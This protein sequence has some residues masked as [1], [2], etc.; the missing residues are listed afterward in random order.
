MQ[1]NKETEDESLLEPD[2]GL[3]EQK[4]LATKRRIEDAA[5]RLVDES[6]FDEVTIEQICEAAGISRRTFFNYFSAK[7]GAVIGTKSEKLSEEQRQKFINATDTNIIELMV[8]HLAQHLGMEHQNSEIHE[9]RQRIFAR[10]DVAV[11][12][13]AFRKERTQETIEL[14]TQRLTEHPEEQLNPEL[15]PG[16]EAML[17]SAFIREATWMAMSRPDRDC[18]LPLIERIFNS[19]ELIRNYTKGL[20]W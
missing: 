3:R 20:E 17:L 2:I 9:R 11:R 5:T 1:E 18:E 6:S 10:P 4:R 13:M 8:T 7:E 14:I 12:A 19:M 16:T 15:D